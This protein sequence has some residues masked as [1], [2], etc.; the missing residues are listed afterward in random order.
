MTGVTLPSSC[1]RISQAARL[2]SSAHSG[3]HA[4]T[5]WHSREM[6]RTRL[7][8]QTRS[9]PLCRA[10]SRRARAACKYEDVPFRARR[11]ILRCFSPSSIRH[12]RRGVRR[13]Q[14]PPPMPSASRRRF[15]GA[16][17]GSVRPTRQDRGLPTQPRG[18]RSSSCAFVV[19]VARPQSSAEPHGPAVS[20][21][22]R[23]HEAPPP[24][25]ARTDWADITVFFVS[26]IRLKPRSRVAV[27][28]QLGVTYACTRR[29]C[30]GRTKRY[31][32][33]PYR[34]LVRKLRHLATSQP[35]RSSLRPHQRT[36]PNCPGTAGRTPG[37][38]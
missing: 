22:Y 1:T 7:A 16:A 5:R 17:L 6:C 33:G 19:V 38:A 24:C 31:R 9:S 30:A 10:N 3:L 11:L 25:A 21:W 23:A 14:P 26:G 37:P 8:P 27:R 28:P 15:L 29:T 2:R 32:Q 36:A 12:H 35:S 18:R 4:S 20:F 13:S 34:W